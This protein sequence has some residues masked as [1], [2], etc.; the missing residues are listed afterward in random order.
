MDKG[1][2]TLTFVNP[3]QSEEEE[4]KMEELHAD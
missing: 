3:K 2:V 4:L 1:T